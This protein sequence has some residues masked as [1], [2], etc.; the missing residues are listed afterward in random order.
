MQKWFYVQMTL[1]CL[2]S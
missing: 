1:T 2:F